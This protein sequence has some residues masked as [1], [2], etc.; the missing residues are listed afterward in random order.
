MQ[1][2]R[3]WFS[4]ALAL[5]VLLVI[6]GSLIFMYRELHRVREA[7]ED[8]TKT[9][10]ITKITEQPS[11]AHVDTQPARKQLWSDLQTELQNAVLQVFSQVTEFNWVEPYKTP[12]QSESAGSAFFINEQGDIITNAHVVNQA[13][14]VTVQ[15]PSVGKRRF[16]VDVIGVSPE[17]DLALLRMRE[18]DL[19]ELKQALGVKTL[20]YLKMGDS[21]AVKRGDKIMALGFPLGQQGLKSTT[22]VVSGREHLPLS[23]Y[24]IQISAP[25]NPGNSGG[26]SIDYAGRAIGV[27]TAGIPGAQNVGYIIPSNE[28]LLFLD[29]LE[30]VKTKGKPKLLRRPFLGVFFNT[31]NDNLRA[32]LKNPPPGGLY[33][34]DVYKGGPFDKAGIKGG[35]MIYSIDSYPIDMHGEMSVP[36]SKEDRISIIDYVA[37]LKLGHIVKLV[38]YRNGTK[39]TSTFVLT[40]TEPPIRRMYPGF[41]KIEYE[42]LGGF[43]FMPITANHVMLLAKFAPQIMQYADPKKQIDPALLITHV[44]L[45]SPAS[46]LRSIGAGGIISEVNGEKIHTLDEFRNAVLKSTKTGYLTIKTTDNQFAAIPLNDILTH[47]ERLASTYFFRISE[48]FKELK[49]IA[50]QVTSKS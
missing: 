23:G 31:A 34:V 37:R 1:H 38:Y 20:S 4:G 32:Y 11:R 30:T 42:V 35:D 6:F 43:V 27:N 7:L 9:T 19:K 2:N 16:A 50:P 3:Q 25:I 18:K 5:G 39:M 12:S 48:L 44:M 15:I 33:V 13:I 46:E 17:R 41:E 22:G 36:W 8:V 24:F 10:C 45:N 14:S 40:R 29:Q 21:D 47:E 28:V 26:P 49:R